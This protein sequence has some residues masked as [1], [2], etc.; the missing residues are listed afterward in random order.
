MARACCVSLALWDRSYAPCGRT[1][2]FRSSKQFGLPWSYTEQRCYLHGRKY[3]NVRKKPIMLL[4]GCPPY[5]S[6]ACL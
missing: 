6:V 2:A 1:S 5:S 3:A 4:E